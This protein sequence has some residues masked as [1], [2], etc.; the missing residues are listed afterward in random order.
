MIKTKWPK[1]SII[2]PTLNSARTIDEYFKAIK[3]QNYRGEIEIVI[4]DGGSTDKTLEIAKI[5]GA[6][7]YKNSLKTAEAGKALGVKNASGNIYAFIDSDNILEDSGWLRNL[8][9]PLVEDKEIIAS[10][11]I[12]FTYRSSDFWLT[13]YFALIGMGDPL[14]LFIGSYDKYSYVSNRWTN[15]KLEQTKK[16]GYIKVKINKQIPT[17]GANGFL[18]KKEIFNKNTIG[19]YLFDVEIIEDLVQKSPI[20]VSKVNTGIAHLFSGDVGTFVRKQR[21]R[22]RDYLYYRQIKKR[23]GP[24]N[25]SYIYF[26]IFK[27]V[28]SCFLFAPIV[29]QA[30]NGYM[31]KKDIVWLFHI[32]A[33]YITL[34][35]YMYETIRFIFIKEIYNRKG[36]KQ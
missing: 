7:I 4:T 35:S 13:R 31:R 26:G 2:T 18:V 15:L 16:D 9:K 10:E 17:I 8:I 27:F 34:F 5:N 25:S 3:S 29:I 32:P 12:R 24:T 22:I 6:K 14:N 30:L 23:S 21:R 11:P 1:I 19:D 36:W 28:L 20:F 33:C